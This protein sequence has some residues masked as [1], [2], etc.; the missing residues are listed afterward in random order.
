MV[1]WAGSGP[2]SMRAATC[3]WRRTPQGA[4]FHIWLLQDH[5]DTGPSDGWDLW[6]EDASQVDEWFDG[7]LASITWE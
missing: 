1:A 7:E 2:G 5:P 3:R 6:A 4:G